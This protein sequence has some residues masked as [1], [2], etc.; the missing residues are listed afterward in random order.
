MYIHT[1]MYMYVYVCICI[2]IHV[3]I[4]MYMYVYVCICM[5]M[6]VYVCICMYMYVYVCICM[7]MYVYVCICMYM[8]VYV[9]I[10]MYMYVYVCICMYMYVYVYIQSTLRAM[11]IIDGPIHRVLSIIYRNQIAINTLRKFLFMCALISICRLCAYVLCC[12][13]FRQNVSEHKDLWN[14]AFPYLGV[15]NFKQSGSVDRVDLSSFRT[16]GICHMMPVVMDVCYAILA[17]TRAE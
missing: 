12:E 5:Y 16:D 7:Y 6:Y 13:L 11:V 9:C 8:Y 15:I 14:V 3:C 1:C 4:C 17:N 10:C 2:Y